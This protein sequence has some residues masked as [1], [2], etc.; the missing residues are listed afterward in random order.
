MII[1]YK[2]RNLSRILILILMFWMNEYNSHAQDH[3]K[4]EVSI[5][6]FGPIAIEPGAKLGANFLVKQ[7]EKSRLFLNAHTGF[8]AKN[9]DN[10][11]YLVGAELAWRLQKKDKKS[12]TTFSLGTSYLFQQEVI[13]FTVNLEGEITNKHKMNRQL[14]MPALNYEYARFIKPNWMGY[15]KIGYGQQINL[16]NNG[17]HRGVLLWEF[18]VRYSLNRKIK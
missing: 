15:L 18:G 14:V 4:T 2:T 5:G 13:D 9:L 6:Y 3:N 11:N 12:T 8:F 7:F 16:S 1:Q 10:S 17:P